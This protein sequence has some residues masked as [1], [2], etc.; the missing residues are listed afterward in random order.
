MRIKVR[1]WKRGK[2]ETLSSTFALLPFVTFTLALLLAG[3]SI[4]GRAAPEWQEMS[5]FGVAEDLPKV[6]VYGSLGRHLPRMAHTPALD[7]FLYGPAPDP[8]AWLRNP[9]GFTL[10]EPRL[11]VCDQGYPDIIS[12]NLSTGRSAAWQDQSRP[13][14]CPVA[15]AI[16]EDGMVFVADTTLR[17]VLV[18]LPNGGFVEQVTPTEDPAR[19]FRPVALLVHQGVL[20]IGNAGENRIDRWSIGDRQ[21]LMPL[22]SSPDVAGFV[23]PTGLAMTREHTLLVVDSIR[24]RVFRLSTSGEWLEPI[25]KPGRGEGEF[26]RPKQVCVTPSGLICVSDAGRQSVLVFAAD[27]RFITEVREKPDEWRG[28]TLP[29]GLLALPSEGLTSLMAEDRPK[30]DP[31]PDEWLIVS[32]TLSAASLNVLGIF[33]P[34]G[35]EAVTDVP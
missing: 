31:M 24:A 9:Q 4:G 15:I 25:G 14:R 28:F 21:W 18:Y 19:P 17:A 12:V 35:R 13:P 16:D 34:A 2:G 7:E 26:I 29:A 23:A 32:D 10:L 1:R 22:A 3:C 27:G 8:N 11:L 20:H 6:V 5:T 30:P 33:L